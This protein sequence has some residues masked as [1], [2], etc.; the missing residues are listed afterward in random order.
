MSDKD[1]KHATLIALNGYG[2]LLCGKSGVGKSDLAFRLIENHNATLVADDAVL[3]Y[4]QNG[5]IYG[6]VPENLHGL[7]EVRGVGICQYPHLE[8][9]KIDLVVDLLSENEKVE[10]LPK[11]QKV[12]LFN[13][14]LFYLTLHAF[15]ASAPQKILL[16]LR[17]NLLKKV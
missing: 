12:R 9:H 16:K 4:A 5:D 14:E 7:L 6:E 2:V 3:I 13:N 1:L 8:R 17:D 10:R 15:E 11:V